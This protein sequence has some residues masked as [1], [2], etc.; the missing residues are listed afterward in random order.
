MVTVASTKPADRA[1]AEPMCC[2][3]AFRGPPAA[4]EG[5][6]YPLA[7]RGL[8]FWEESTQRIRGAS[9][10]RR[11]RAADRRCAGWW[12]GSRAGTLKAGF[13]RLRG[14]AVS[15]TL[16]LTLLTILLAGPIPV[17]EAVESGIQAP[18]PGGITAGFTGTSDP[19]ALTGRLPFDV[20]SIAIFDLDAQ[21]FHTFVPGA[22]EHVNADS[23][24]LF[25][26]PAIV[27][28]RRAALSPGS[29][30]AVVSSAEP[31]DAG[32]VG[33]VVASG[34]VSPTLG[35]K[36]SGVF[37]VPAPGALTVGIAGTSSPSMLAAAQSFD[38]AAIIVHEVS[39]QAFLVFIPGAPD[40]VNTLT[41]ANLNPDSVVWIRRA[42][43]ASLAL[44]PAGTLAPVVHPLTVPAGPP[45]LA[46]SAAPVASA[47][48]TPHPATSTPPAGVSAP[49][50][51]PTSAPGAAAPLTP[52]PTSAPRAAATPTPLEV[53]RH[54]TYER[55]EDRLES[56][57][58]ST[59][60]G[61]G[62]TREASR[63]GSSAGVALLLPGD[64]KSNNGYRAEWHGVDAVGRGVE[65]WQGISFYLP[66]DWDQGENPKTSDRRT[67][68]QWHATASGSVQVSPIYGLQLS[69]TSD[70][71][72]YAFYRKENYIDSDGRVR[73]KKVV[74]WRQSAPINR[75]VDFAFDTIWST[76]RDGKMDLYVNGELVYSFTGATLTGKT[77]IYSKWGIYGQPTR[78]FFDE[79]RIAEGPGQLRA[80][81]P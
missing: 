17:A 2:R 63:R 43:A 54:T 21:R 41:D 77:N 22:P 67:I 14:F 73:S 11:P 71:P 6:S 72:D 49:V 55:G 61:L 34:P 44:P 12:D 80:V 26:E 27:W 29:S 18:P 47:A 35:T 76:G 5:D 62:V 79:V 56:A 50:S 51:N 81:S 23:E 60:Y 58:T 36:V 9:R 13:M 46:P 16:F 52:E 40:R 69:G 64:S 3:V 75:W 19:D 24:D 57:H 38:V 8:A 10:V 31:A 59:S 4:F 37:P 30:P 7:H 20:D 15:I 39:T 65:R 25:G 33:G 42:E 53:L 78:I 74:L 1:I 48:S 70:A 68:F 45:V 28:V 66:R 32:A